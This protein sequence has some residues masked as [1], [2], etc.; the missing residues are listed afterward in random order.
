MMDNNCFLVDWLSF[1][2]ESMGHL[3]MMEYLGLNSCD[4]MHSKGFYGYQKR[5]WC[6]GMHIHYDNPDIPGV[7]VEMSGTGCRAFETFGENL[8]MS[9]DG[10]VVADWISVFTD[11]LTR[12]DF[13]ITRLDIAFDDKSGCI[14]LDRVASDV[15]AGNFVSKF[16]S[17]SVSV[18]A[19][20]GNIGQTVYLGS[21]QSETRMRIYDKAFERGFTS[22]T[23][24]KKY[25]WDGSNTAKHDEAISQTINISSQ[26][27]DEK[28]VHW[29]RFEMQLRRDRAFSF[30]SELAEADY[31]IGQVFS[32]VVAN[33]FRIVVPSEDS[34][35]RRWETAEYW[36]ELVG[37][38]LPLSLWHN[39]DLEYNKAKCEKYVY[40]MAGNSVYALIE[41]EGLEKFRQI[42]MKKKS[43]K[44][45]Q[46][47]QNMISEERALQKVRG[48]A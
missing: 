28:P 22:V 10:E 48:T 5:V 20:P 27:S 14:P 46:R 47:I 2:C 44:I 24:N 43:R 11:I 29:V 21:A 39:K 37:D 41:L 30:L 26:N 1:R 40:S 13:I 35:K 7:L 19:H 36:A 42:L 45:P 12:K 25:Q 23:V 34:N 6:S 32:R 9:A 17:D 4:W 38:V 8:R 3:E 18:T 15:M 31:D 16:K 33:Y